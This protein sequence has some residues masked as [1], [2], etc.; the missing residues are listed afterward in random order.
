MS[1]RFAFDRMELAGSLG[2]LGTLL[3]I[4]IALVLVNGI[5]PLGL[6]FSIGVYY[7]IAGMVF[8][9]TGAIDFIR[10]AT[11][12]SVIRKILLISGGITFIMG[13]S[14]YQILQNAAEPSFTVQALG[15]VLIGLI[16]G[17]ATALLALLLLDNR[18]FPAEPGK[19]NLEVI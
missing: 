6:F 5:S 11:P 10:R 4:A 1:R 15:P 12:K 9:F 19:E 16:I 13:I 17:I 3:P 2:D 18:K 7:I 14:A 8:G